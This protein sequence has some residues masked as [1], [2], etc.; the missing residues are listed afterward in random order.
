MSG[1]AVLL[2]VRYFIRSKISRQLLRKLTQEADCCV[3]PVVRDHS[4]CLVRDFSCHGEYCRSGGD[5]DRTGEGLPSLWHH[6]GKQLAIAETVVLLGL[7]LS[8]LG[9]AIPV[10]AIER[11]LPGSG[12]EDV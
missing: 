9:G 6:K 11:A 12:S 5:L 3:Q 8:A 1:P 4:H 7:L 2:D 10:P